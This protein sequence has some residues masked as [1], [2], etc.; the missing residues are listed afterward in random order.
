MRRS[1]YNRRV[2]VLSLKGFLASSTSDKER[3]FFFFI[4]EDF[5]RCIFWYVYYRS[6]YFWRFLTC[7]ISQVIRWLN[8]VLLFAGRNKFYPWDSPLNTRISPN[9]TMVKPRM[10]IATNNS[11]LRMSVFFCSLSLGTNHAWIAMQTTKKRFKYINVVLIMFFCF[12]PADSF[13][14]L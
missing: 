11:G 4:W 5:A 7:V 3:M 14:N 1:Y 10:A 9:R 12:S 6:I 8:S 2:I 13:W